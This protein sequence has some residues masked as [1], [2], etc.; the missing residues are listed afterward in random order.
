M[1]AYIMYSQNVQKSEFHIVKEQRDRVKKY[2]S[3]GTT[4][5]ITYSVILA[6]FLGFVDLCTT[7]LWRIKLMGRPRA[8]RLPT[9]FMWLII[10]Y[11]TWMS[12]P[13][14]LSTKA[15]KNVLDRVFQSFQD[16]GLS[17]VKALTSDS[18]FVY[19]NTRNQD[20]LSWF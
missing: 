14:L 13:F 10:F 16:V 18:L 6:H 17:K 5:I 11:Q 20:L 8:D 3:M 1:K 2:L 7:L 12:E 4:Y 19:L 9:L 15:Q